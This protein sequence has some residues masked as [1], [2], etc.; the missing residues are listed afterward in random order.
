M[1]QPLSVPHADVGCPVEEGEHPVDRALLCSM[2]LGC[3]RV[4][5]LKAHRGSRDDITEGE[6]LS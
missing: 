4:L 5:S 2:R 1:F 6:T 3:S